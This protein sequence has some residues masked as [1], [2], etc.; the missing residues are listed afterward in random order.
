MF[1]LNTIIKSTLAILVIATSTNAWAAEEKTTDPKA[2]DQKVTEQKLEIGQVTSSFDITVYGYIKL[3]A[4]YDSQA[5]VIGDLGFFVK[6][7]IDGKNDNEFNMTARE[8]RLGLKI[9]GPTVYDGKLSGRLEI[10]FYGRSDSE[11]GY[12]PRLRL[13]YIDWAFE[14]WSMRFGQD[15]ETFITVAPKTV[16][17]DTM[18]DKGALGLRRAQARLT[19]NFNLSETSSI[20]VKAAAATTIA[21]DA[22]Q[23]GQV[24]G[25]DSGVPT[26]QYNL[27]YMGKILTEK[28]SR[29]SVSGHYGTETYH[30]E[31]RVDSKN[32]DTWSV[33]GS[34]Y[35]PVVDCVTLA[36]TI[37]T[38]SNLDTYFGG[39]GQ[40]INS[41]DDEGIGASGGW[42]Q[43]MYFPTEKLNLNLI[44][45][46]DDPD[47]EDI[48][49]G[50]RSKN[51]VIGVNGYYSFTKALIGCLEYQRI[52]TD[53]YMQQEAEDN[54]FQAA[55]KYVF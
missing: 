45:G 49:E 5:T 44:Y 35:M 25:K 31:G 9:G 54:R 10:D 55:M 40:G 15:W 24:D 8:T 7:K 36:G 28:K 18:A 27:G 39:I 51:T 29:M 53:Y 2:A 50:M 38:G 21:P 32:V 30:Y 26:F 37:W 6:P 46:I 3:D 34:L 41:I 48:N 47:N 12:H 52:E 20:F 13:G 1:K 11:N 23:D 17:F 4:I 43:L 22:D 16:N 42:V 33:I 19:K 14:N